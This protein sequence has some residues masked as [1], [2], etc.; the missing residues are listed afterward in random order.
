MARPSKVRFAATDIPIIEHAC[1]LALKLLT[2]AKRDMK[3]LSLPTGSVESFI[4]QVGEINRVVLRAKGGDGQIPQET[5]SLE[6]HL[7][8]ALKVGNFLYLDELDKLKDQ[9][10][11]ADIAEAPEIDSRR[12]TVEKLNERLSDQLLLLGPQGVNDVKLKIER[13]GKD[14]AAGDKPEALDEE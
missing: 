4:T 1:A 7:T 12:R 10:A 5:F 3:R 11:K 8:G 2:K 14:L 6:P 9:Q 13:A